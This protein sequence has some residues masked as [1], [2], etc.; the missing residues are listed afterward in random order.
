MRRDELPLPGDFDSIAGKLK[1]VDDSINQLLDA[2]ERA[3]S[4]DDDDDVLVELLADIS[5]ALIVLHLVVAGM[6][7]N[8]QRCT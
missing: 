5:A 3:A 1:V 6:L 2:T 4:S 8:D 7:E